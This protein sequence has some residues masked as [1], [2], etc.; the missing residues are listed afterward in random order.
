MT[1]TVVKTSILSF[2]KPS[3]ESV[4]CFF[5][6]LFIFLGVLGI[7]SKILSVLGKYCIAEPHPQALSST[8]YIWESRVTKIVT[9]LGSDGTRHVVSVHAK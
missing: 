2:R 5:V 1:V 8:F 9:Q 4:R 7:E 3:K 6:C